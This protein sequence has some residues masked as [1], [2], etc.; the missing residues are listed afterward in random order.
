MRCWP[1][2]PGNAGNAAGTGKTSSLISGSKT[3]R[4]AAILTNEHNEHCCRIPAP[5]TPPTRLNLE[6][7]P[8]PFGE[9]NQGMTKGSCRTPQSGLQKVV[10]PCKKRHSLA[11]CHRHPH[12]RLSL[13]ARTGD[14][15]LEAA[16]TALAVLPPSGE[17]PPCFVGIFLPGFHKQYPQLP[18]G[19]SLARLQCIFW[20]CG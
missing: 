20:F 17:K 19:G 6:Q 18:Y 9:K 4:A 12:L 15:S 3:E 13:R 1:C 2:P 14:R 5:C 16:V 11:L 8:K 10:H 7:E